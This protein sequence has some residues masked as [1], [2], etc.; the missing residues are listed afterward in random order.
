MPHPLDS[1]V[2]HCKHYYPYGYGRYAVF[3]SGD[4]DGDGA[5]D[6]E[7]FQIR[8]HTHTRM[9]ALHFMPHIVIRANLSIMS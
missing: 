9:H 8:A 5:R 6:D 7:I 1:N 2:S 4:D 3:H